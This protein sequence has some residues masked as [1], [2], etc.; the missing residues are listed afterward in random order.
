MRA[1]GTLTD[2]A[3]PDKTKMPRW[4]IFILSWLGYLC[5]SRTELLEI[6][7]EISKVIDI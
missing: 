7:Q 4:D 2:P 5:N 3:A 6:G 1:V